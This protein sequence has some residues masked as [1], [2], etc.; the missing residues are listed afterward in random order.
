MTFNK[1]IQTNVVEYGKTVILT[2]LIVG[3]GSFVFGVQYQ[4]NATVT[5][6]NKVVLS[7]QAAP[8]ETTEVKK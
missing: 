7:S 5:V 8:A 2:A 4:K 3:I 1:Q 6:E